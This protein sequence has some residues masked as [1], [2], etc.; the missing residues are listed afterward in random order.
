MTFMANSNKEAFHFFIKLY[1][2]FFCIFVLD[3]RYVRH[4]FK[5]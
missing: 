5:G 2:I 3:F 1:R 4:Y